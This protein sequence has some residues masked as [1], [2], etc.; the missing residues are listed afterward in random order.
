[1]STS[2]QDGGGFG[3]PSSSNPHDSA[4]IS[5][6]E[7]RVRQMDLWGEQD[8][9]PLQWIALLTEELGEAAE[10]VNDAFIPPNDPQGFDEDGYREE[11]VHVAAVAV[12]AI[13]ALDRERAEA[14]E[15]DGE[16]VG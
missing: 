7:E 1:M 12:A 14:E 15:V 8:H 4:F 6:G 3:R 5:V 9:H 11:L 13:T 16:V 2:T 10:H